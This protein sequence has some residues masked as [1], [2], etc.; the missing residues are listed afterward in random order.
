MIMMQTLLEMNE[1]YRFETNELFRAIVR[2]KI[3][4]NV[5]KIKGGEDLGVGVAKLV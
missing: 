3:F 2:I 1:E 5:C 4:M